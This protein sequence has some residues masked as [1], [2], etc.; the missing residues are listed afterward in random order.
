MRLGWFIAAV[1]VSSLTAGVNGE[2]C[3]AGQYEG[4]TGCVKRP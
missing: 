2:G 4:A 1:V 3:L